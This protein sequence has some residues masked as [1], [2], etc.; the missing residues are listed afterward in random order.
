LEHAGYVFDVGVAVEHGALDPHAMLGFARGESRRPTAAT[1]KRRD[2]ESRR[3]DPSKLGLD[4]VHAK[5]NVV[6]T[7]AVRLQ[8]C[9]ERVA[10][11]QRL[12]ELEPCVAQIEV[13]QAHRNLRRLIDGYHFKPQA[14]TEVDQGCFGVGNQH[15][16]MVEASDHF[17]ARVCNAGRSAKGVKS[18]TGSARR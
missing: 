9:G 8:P 13:G 6:Q 18:R 2:R 14:V 11:V 1:A 17:V 10:G 7:F 15:G 12:D 5:A 16:D 4:V 3:T